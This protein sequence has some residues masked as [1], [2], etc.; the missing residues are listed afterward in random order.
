MQTAAL[1]SSHSDSAFDFELDDEPDYSLEDFE[2]S[3]HPSHLP[4]TPPSSGSE[5]ESES[6]SEPNSVSEFE[7]AFESYSESSLDSHQSN[8]DSGPQPSAMLQR[9]QNNQSAHKG[10]VATP[11]P[12]PVSARAS[13]RTRAEAIAPHLPF[14]Y[15]TALATIRRQ[16]RQL[17][18]P[19]QEA[20]SPSPRY[21]FVESRGL[22]TVRAIRRRAA[23]EGIWF[24]SEDGLFWET[25][26]QAWLTRLVTKERSRWGFHTSIPE[27]CRAALKWGRERAIGTVMAECPLCGC[28]CRER[29]RMPAPQTSARTPDDDTAHFL[30]IMAYSLVGFPAA[31]FLVGIILVALANWLGVNGNG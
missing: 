15:R 26:G 31:G 16:E 25:G 18:H 4:P 1:S 13:P 6:E 30:Y 9:S 2:T 23:Q 12:V 22:D 28:Q 11:E 27:L 8:I 5:S 17:A 29:G 14:L 20:A 19:R 3:Y 21:I 7:S 24:V 10:P